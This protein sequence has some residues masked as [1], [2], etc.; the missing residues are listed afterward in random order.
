M[1]NFYRL[2]EDA[3]WEK[4]LYGSG[5]KVID[6]AFNWGKIGTKERMEALAGYIAQARRLVKSPVEKQRLAW[7]VDGVW[8]PMLAGRA[9]Y[10]RKQQFRSRPAPEASTPEATLPDALCT[11]LAETLLARLVE[12]GL[13]D[14]RWQPLSLSNAEK[15][16]LASLLAG[17][18][19]V[20][21]QWQTFGRLW[22]LKPETLRTAYNKGMDQPRSNAFIQRV[23]KALVE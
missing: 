12:A 7:F 19:K 8:K 22:G 11:P 18:L 1:R 21:N 17:R 10:D 16:V 15:G 20:N 6:E 23:N 9:G 14:E 2:V 3:A 13:V 4:S 5:N